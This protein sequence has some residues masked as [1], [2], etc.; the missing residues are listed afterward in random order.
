MSLLKALKPVDAYFISWANL[1]EQIEA[2][3]K[4][5]LA[6]E[7]VLYANQDDDVY[8]A[9][10]S[11][12]YAFSTKELQ[13]LLD[14]TDAKKDI[15]KESIP[16]DSTHTQCLGMGLCRLLLSQSLQARWSY[17]MIS[18]EGL[19]IVDVKAQEDTNG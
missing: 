2:A 10:M 1:E 16:T 17:E 7:V 8:W 5:I 12:S 19:W 14:A 4:R 11:K 13:C 15:R 18:E 3:I 6:Q 9:V